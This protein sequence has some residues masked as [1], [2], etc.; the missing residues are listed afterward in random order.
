MAK[1]G[2]Y[3][4]VFYGHD[5]IK[6]MEVVWD[7]LLLNPWEVSAHKTHTATYAVYDTDSN[8]AEIHALKNAKN[9]Y[10]KENQE[11]RKNLWFLS[12]PAL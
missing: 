12:N 3:D 1:S 11:Y 10:S 2:D 6:N 4:A 9:I 5:H 8:T 7:C